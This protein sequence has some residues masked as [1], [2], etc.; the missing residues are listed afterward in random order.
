[1]KA[2]Y[3]SPAVS[4]SMNIPKQILTSVILLFSLFLF[5]FIT[6]EASKEIAFISRGPARQ[7]NE[8]LVKYYLATNDPETIR[9]VERT[10]HVQDLDDEDRDAYYAKLWSNY[11]NAPSFYIGLGHQMKDDPLYGVF[12]N[13]GG[14]FRAIVTDRTAYLNDPLNKGEEAN[15]SVV[16]LTASL[17]GLEEHIRLTKEYISS[18]NREAFRAALFAT[19]RQYDEVLN[20]TGELSS[21]GELDFLSETS[22]S[23]PPSDGAMTD[24]YQ[25]I[26]YDAFTRSPFGYLNEVARQIVVDATE[27]PKLRVKALRYLAENTYSSDSRYLIQFLFEFIAASE[28]QNYLIEKSTPTDYSDQQMLLDVLDTL[29]KEIYEEIERAEKSAKEL[30]REVQYLDE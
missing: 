5:V 4:I 6:L 20:I 1:M 21:A 11:I 18:G 24:K 12:R 26:I 3:S 15:P 29:S 27:E 16:D 17:T 28:Q 19:R 22:L 8:M 30:E 7:F 2:D 13:R 25:F 14:D 10:I 23:L 9:F